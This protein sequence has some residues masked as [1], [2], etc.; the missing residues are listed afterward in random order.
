MLLLNIYPGLGYFI[1]TTHMQR[2]QIQIH[3]KGS[4]ELT[5]CWVKKRISLVNLLRVQ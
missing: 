3:Y 4:K 5:V 1:P 2:Q